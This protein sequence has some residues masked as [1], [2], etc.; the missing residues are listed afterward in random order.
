MKVLNNKTTLFLAR[1]V[2]R[3]YSPSVA[4]PERPLTAVAAVFYLVQLAHLPWP[5]QLVFTAITALATFGIILV[6]ARW[7]RRRMSRENPAPGVELAI[8]AVLIL[9]FYLF[10]AFRGQWWLMVLPAG[11][12]LWLFSAALLRRTGLIYAG[13][14]ALLCFSLAVGAHRLLLGQQWLFAFGSY[15]LQIRAAQALAAERD[16]RSGWQTDGDQRILRENGADVLKLEIPP[17]SHFHE[18]ESAGFVYG[19]PV[20]GRPIAY[21]SADVRD[22]ARMPAL[23]IFA[24][25]RIRDLIGNA[26]PLT[27]GELSPPVVDSLRETIEQAL[28]FRERA[29]EIENLEYAGTAALPDYLQ[30]PAEIQSAAGIAYRFTDRVLDEPAFLRLYVTPAYVIVV[31]DAPRDGARFEPAVLRIL[32]GIDLPI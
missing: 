4:K 19:V 24:T 30:L 27:D 13:L 17:G 12:F 20:P 26:S 15:A 6:V 2:N 25:D 31:F 29:G 22:P 10:D 18:G 11:Y 8:A 21:I 9:S 14:V 32:R 5:F 7:L 23:A 3:F 1:L 28:R 16:A